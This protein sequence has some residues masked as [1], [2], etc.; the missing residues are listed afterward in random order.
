VRTTATGTIQ[1]ML[2]TALI[3]YITIATPRNLPSSLPSRIIRA[4]KILEKEPSVLFWRIHYYYAHRHLQFTTITDIR[5]FHVH[6]IRRIYIPLHHFSSSFVLRL[7][8]F[9]IPTTSP[10]YNSSY[11]HSPY[12]Y[13]YIHMSIIQ[14]YIATRIQLSRTSLLYIYF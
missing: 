6:S 11:I 8:P 13:I 12:I 5:I 3:I 2:I 7:S 10:F 1:I 4:G 14:Y 9:R